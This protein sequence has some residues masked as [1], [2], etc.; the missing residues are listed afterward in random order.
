MESFT[1][2]YLSSCFQINYTQHE[3]EFWSSTH[4]LVDY[5]DVKTIKDG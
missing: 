2:S 4:S 1:I 5:V 3:L